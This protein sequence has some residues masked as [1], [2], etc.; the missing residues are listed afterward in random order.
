MK[1]CTKCGLELPESE[2]YKRKRSPD[3]LSYQCK[4]CTKKRQKPWYEKNKK[5]IKERLRQYYEENK[6][7]ILEYRHSERFRLFN[8]QGV[9]I[10]SKKNPEKIKA[11]Q[12][13]NHKIRIGEIERPIECEICGEESKEPLNGHHEDY[14]KPLDV[15]WLCI[16]CHTDL[17]VARR[18]QSSTTQEE[19]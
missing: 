17:H 13:L 11:Q 6:E 2:F 9:R 5:R 14:S 10:Y 7:R 8:A 19:K 12:V 18:L 15:I 3:G 4:M 1:T 16:K